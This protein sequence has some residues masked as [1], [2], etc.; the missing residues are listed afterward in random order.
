MRTRVARGAPPMGTGWSSHRRKVALDIDINTPP[1]A[2]VNEVGTS[3]HVHLEAEAAPQVA[4]PHPVTIDVD[5]LDDDVILV[6][7]RAFVEAK[8][9]V[10]KKS[11]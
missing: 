8:K 1:C 11:S 10:K 3:S 9:Q 5:S 4:P 6:S 2:N 7:P